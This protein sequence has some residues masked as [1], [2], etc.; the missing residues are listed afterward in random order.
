MGKERERAE[1]Q[2]IVHFLHFKAFYP[3]II[4]MRCNAFLSHLVAVSF[5][6]KVISIGIFI[7]TPIPL[8]IPVSVTL[9]LACDPS[10]RRN[11]F[12]VFLR[13]RDKLAQNDQ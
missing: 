13:K 1:L 8:F 4:I 9:Q 2:K 10:Q 5:P 6:T 11:L 12:N 3:I 7:P